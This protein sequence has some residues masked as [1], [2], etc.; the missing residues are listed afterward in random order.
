MIPVEQRQYGQRPWES[1]T[2]AGPPRSR[3]SSYLL[4]KTGRHAFEAVDLRVSLSQM[5][6][7]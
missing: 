2:G 7:A 1:G 6:L 3:Q 5:R 4:L